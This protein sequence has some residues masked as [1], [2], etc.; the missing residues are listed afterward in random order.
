MIESPCVRD[1]ILNDNDICQGCYRTVAEVKEWIYLNDRERQE[2]INR[3][4]DRKIDFSVIQSD[5]TPCNG[6]M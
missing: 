4:K 1:C 6:V 2:V 5:S 3:I